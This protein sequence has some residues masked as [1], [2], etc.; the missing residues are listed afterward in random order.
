MDEVIDYNWTKPVLKGSSLKANCYMKQ[1]PARDFVYCKT[2]KG[3]LALSTLHKL[4]LSV[5]LEEPM[6]QI[7][8]ILLITTDT[9]SPAMKDRSVLTR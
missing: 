3:Q 4:G 2:E 1:L 9:I 8:I 5:I 6:K 7:L